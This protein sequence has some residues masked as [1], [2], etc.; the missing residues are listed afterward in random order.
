MRLPT[1]EFR[2]SLIRQPRL[3]AAAAVAVGLLGVASA[4][5]AHTDVQFS[6][7]IPGIV[8]APVYGPQYVEP[9][10]VY[11]QPQPV[12]VQPQPVYVQ[13]QPVYVRRGYGYGQWRQDDWRRDEWRREEWR[14]HEWREHHGDRD[15]DHDRRHRD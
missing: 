3:F 13:P 11:V 9:A 6:I 7:G 1:K 15:G 10:P 2:M 4:A 12:Y 14:R 8:A 5:Q